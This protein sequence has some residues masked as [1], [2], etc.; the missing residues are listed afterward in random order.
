MTPLSIC[1]K[2]SVSLQQT[3]TIC[4]VESKKKKSEQEREI[5]RK[6]EMSRTF[7]A[8]KEVRPSL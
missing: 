4:A 1:K 5:I 8:V 3:A 2:N 6:T 7:L